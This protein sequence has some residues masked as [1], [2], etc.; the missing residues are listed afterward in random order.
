MWFVLALSCILSPVGE[1]AAAAEL[2]MVRQPGCSWCIRWDREIGEKYAASAEGRAAPVRHVLLSDPLLKNLKG[3][4]TITPTFLL[5]DEGREVDRMVGYP[6][7]SFFWEILSEM[8]GK[9][10]GHRPS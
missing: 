1:G 7:E 6:G 2:V 3:P 10:P 5:I 8:L 9:L 4:V